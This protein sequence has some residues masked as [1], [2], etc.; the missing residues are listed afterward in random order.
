MAYQ[1]QTRTIE[2]DGCDPV[3]IT[4]AYTP[5][6]AYIGDEAWAQKLEEL[7]I[8]PE[9][10][11][12][13]NEVCSI[14]FCEREQKWYGWSHRAM[15]GFGIG[16]TVAKG[17]CAYTADTVDGLIEDYVGFFADVC[18]PDETRALLVPDYENNRVWV[19]EKHYVATMASSAE[20]VALAIECPE[21]LPQG[22]ITMGGYWMGVGRGAWT[23]R[24]LEDAK[25][26]ACDFAEG[27]G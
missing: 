7:G 2:M 15:W 17:D 3:E 13:D 18:D 20:G 6:G 25:Q 1:L 27:V 26:M 19:G 5:G 23:A 10:R 8:A 11:A 22:Q 4:S 12:P 14:G 21:M 24:T 16:D 9:L